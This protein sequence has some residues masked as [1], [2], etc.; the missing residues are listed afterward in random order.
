MEKDLGVP[1]ETLE[2]VREKTII[3]VNAATRFPSPRNGVALIPK[4]SHRMRGLFK[5]A[6]AFTSRSEAREEEGRGRPITAVRLMVET[7]RPRPETRAASRL[8]REDILE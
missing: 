2:R 3:F 4:Y 8:R 6:A 1:D 7:Y 5:R